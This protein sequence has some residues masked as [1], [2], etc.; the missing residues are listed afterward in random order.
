[1]LTRSHRWAISAALIPAALA[2]A[3][4]GGGGYGGSGSSSSGGGGAA[5]AATSGAGGSAA[6][7]VTIADFKYGPDPVQVK[8]GGSITWTNSDSTPHTATDTGDTSVLDTGT[9]NQGDS[10]TVT[11]EQ[12]GTYRYTCSFHPFM[13]GTVTVT[14]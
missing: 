6:A 1:M 10:K 13:H 4:C 14:K 3:G 11:F 7:N 12:P 2:V 9:L 5:P 8:S